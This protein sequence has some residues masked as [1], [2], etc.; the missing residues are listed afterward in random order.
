MEGNKLA[1]TKDNLYLGFKYLSK[2]FNFM[3]QSLSFK[4]P[5]IFF[6]TTLSIWFISTLQNGHF[7][8]LAFALIL[9]FG[10]LLL[11]KQ[12]GLK[13][14]LG[15]SIFMISCF[16]SLALLSELSEFESFNAKAFNML[17][18]GGALIVSHM[19]MSVV[20]L[21]SSYNKEKENEEYV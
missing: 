2:N 20:L 11:K 21:C 14:F 17:A 16:F 3:K 10:L 4:A 9:L 8:Y 5:C 7:N 13:L 6:I 1:Y 15:L 18:V 12:E 19:I